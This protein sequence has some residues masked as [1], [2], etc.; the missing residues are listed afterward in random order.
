MHEAEGARLGLDYRYRS[1]D[2]DQLHL[3]DGALG[4]LVGLATEIGLCGLNVTHPFKE[5]VVESLSDLAPEVIEI[6]AVNTIVLRG[7]QRIG[8]N[9]DTWGFAES[10]RRN[11]GGASLEHV[12]LIG[13]GGAGMAVAHALLDLGAG[14]V[15]VFDIKPEKATALAGRLGNSNGTQRVAAADDLAGV[16]PR[17]SGVVNA[18]PVGMTKYPGMPVP[19]ASLR[20]SQ[21]VADIVYVPEDT[22]LLRA[23]RE[24][25]CR[26]LAGSGMA[27]F[28]AIRAFELITGRVSDAEHMTRHFAA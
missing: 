20:S 22:M 14:Q 2:F 26:T 1:I 6:G 23:A 13:A 28:Q 18:T 7:D 12:A 9:T 17:A 3:D 4:P 19:E 25:G 21:W 24:A 15:S 11:M 5:Q 8:H 16:L 10:F 27:I